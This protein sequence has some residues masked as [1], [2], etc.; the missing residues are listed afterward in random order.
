MEKP[1][2]RSEFRVNAQAEFDEAFY[3]LIVNFLFVQMLQRIYVLQINE[4]RGKKV[5]IFTCH[6]RSFST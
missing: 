3:D 5:F 2:T 1:A 4:I 6:Y